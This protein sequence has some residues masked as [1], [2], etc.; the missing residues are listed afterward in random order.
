MSQI[1]Q[2]NVTVPYDRTCVVIMFIFGKFKLVETCNQNRSDVTKHIR[3]VECLIHV[4][5][6]RILNLNT[7]TKP[8]N[9]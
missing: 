8:V 6:L 9:V 7:Q 5:S 2:S 1:Y 4:V 3:A